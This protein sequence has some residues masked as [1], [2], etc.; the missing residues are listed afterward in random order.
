[1]DITSDP[2]LILDENGVCNYCHNF[3]ELVKKEREDIKYSSL[4]ELFTEIK[5]KSKN[6]EYDCI[7]GISGGVDSSYLAYLLHKYEL[8]V[9]A[10]HVDCGWNSELGVKNIEKICRKYEYDLHTIVI[11]WPTMKRLQRAFL[12]SGMANQDIPQDH[13]FMAATW[14][15]AAKH[16]IRYVISGHNVATEGILSTAYQTY[17]ADWL[18]I[19]DVF[20]KSGEPGN[21]RKYPHLSLFDRYIKYPKIHRLQFI[22]PLQLVD[23]SQRKAIKTLEDECGWQYYGSKHYESRFTKFY[24]DTYLP[25]RF[26]WDKRRDHLASLVVGGELSREEALKQITI[27]PVSDEEKEQEKEYVLKKLDI[28]LSDWNKIISIPIEETQKYM[29]TER[30]KMKLLKVMKMFKKKR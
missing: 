19:K 18:N 27:S 25:E 10:I 29:T 30:I 2:N 24:Q 8:R 22:R 20:R 12:Y 14:K 15:I 11:D 5:R 7:L 3:D 26:G 16:G 6:K 13:A 21:I 9:L 4:D 1:M 23:Y 17:W 28:P